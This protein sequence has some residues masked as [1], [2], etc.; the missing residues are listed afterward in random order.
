M[1][2]CSCGYSMQ[3]QA[4]HLMEEDGTDCLVTLGPVKA[5]LS[6]S[7]AAS[8]LQEHVQCGVTNGSWASAMVFT[9][10]R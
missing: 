9:T 6:W 1:G 4:G 3:C 5:P 8:A 10:K 7:P 2:G